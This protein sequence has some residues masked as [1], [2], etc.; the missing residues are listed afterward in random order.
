VNGVQHAIEQLHQ[1]ET[2]L[3]GQ[4][5]ELAGRHSDEAEIR[6]VSHDIAR[7]SREHVRML[8]E[9]G[10]RRGIDLDTEAEG[11]QPGPLHRLRG[12]VAG[13]VGTGTAPGLALLDDLA[14]AYLAAS[15]NS[16]G[17]EMLA[18][19]A[20]AKRDE[21]LLALATRCHPQTLRQL[22]WANTMI[23]TQAPQIL[24]SL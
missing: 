17:W 20:Q 13:V 23:K 24:A 18:Q 22:R 4:L 15:R 5:R 14:E 1:G 10:Q 21:D 19:V 9:H 3:V 12:A 8:A 16:L 11:G 6:H 2:A 7:W